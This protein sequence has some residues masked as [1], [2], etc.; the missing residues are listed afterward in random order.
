MN[1]IRIAVRKATEEGMERLLKILQADPTIYRS[2]I[3]L[4]NKMH[5]KPS[6]IRRLIKLM[7]YNGIG[8]MSVYG[9]YILSSH[10]KQKDDVHFLR[11]CYGH[12]VSDYMAYKAAEK[13]IFKRWKTVEDQRNLKLLLAPISVNLYGSR[14]YQLLSDISQKLLA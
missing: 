3:V 1:Q 12:Y 2:A 4:A 14:Q 6:R 8:V 13:D 9:G 5:C 10:A 11:M 7:R